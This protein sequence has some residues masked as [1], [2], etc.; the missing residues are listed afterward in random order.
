MCD[1][2]N[3]KHKLKVVYASIGTWGEADVVRWCSD[4]G[5][6]VVD[7]EVDNR[8]NPGGV[9]KMEFPKGTTLNM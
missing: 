6:V 9:R 4:C 7:V 8:I 5:A 2:A 3:G 1:K